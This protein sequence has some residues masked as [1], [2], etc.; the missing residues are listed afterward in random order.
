MACPAAPQRASLVFDDPAITR[1]DGGAQ[2]AV[3][4][5]SHV[6]LH[7]RLAEGSP[8]DHPVLESA[9]QISGGSIQDSHPL[10][11]EPFDADIQARLTGLKDFSAQTLAG[12]VS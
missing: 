8:T 1:L 5:A 2:T 12:A 4:R 7:G 3:A 6:E 10:L 11:A 9:L